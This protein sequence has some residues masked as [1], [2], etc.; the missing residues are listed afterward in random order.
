MGFTLPLL[1]RVFFERRPNFGVALGRLY[2]WNTIGAVCGA[3]AGDAFLIRKV[4]VVGAA[5][6]AASCNV[7][8]AFG[9]MAT[10]LLVARPDAVRPAAEPQ[11]TLAPAAALRS[12][13]RLYALL[14]AAFVSGGIFLALEVVWFRF[15]TLFVHTDS[16][17]FSLMLAVV[18]LGIGAGG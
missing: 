16:L 7:L 3:V 8:A 11:P 2:G 14:A 4:G 18:L 1:V 17:A 15:L 10:A 6:A 5:A 12:T 13:P 9:G